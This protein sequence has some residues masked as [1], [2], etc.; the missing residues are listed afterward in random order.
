VS[1]TITEIAASNLRDDRPLSH[2][3]ETTH[4][5]RDWLRDIDGLVTVLAERPERTWGLYASNAYDF[6]VGLFALW[7]SGKI[8]VVAPNDTAG[9]L[10]A[11]GPSVEALL[12][13]LPGALSIAQAPMAN[14]RRCTRTGIDPKAELV[15]FTSGTSGQPKL[16]RKNIAQ[17]DAETATLERM[18]GEELKERV[19]VATVSHQ[20]IYGLLF[21]IL[22]PLSVRRPFCA[23]TARDPSALMKMTARHCRSVCV[24]SPA[25]LKRL[26]SGSLDTLRSGGD[27]VMFS[28]GGLLPTPVAHRLARHLGRPPIEVYGSTETGGIACREQWPDHTDTPWRPL[29][30]VAIAA[31]NDG[32]RVRSP[33]LPDEDWHLTGDQG[34]LTPDGQFRLGPRIDRIAKVEDK[35]VSLV[36]LESELAAITG[37]DEAVCRVR[38]GRRDLICAVIALDQVGFREL[39]S[40][41]RRRYVRRLRDALARRFD[42]VTVPR[43]WRFMESLP[44]NEQGKVSLALLNGLFDPSQPRRF[45]DVTGIECPNDHEVVLTLFVRKDLI[46]FVGHFPEAPVLPGVTQLFWADHFARQLF[47]WDL[48]WNAMEAVKFN[49]V[50]FPGMTV[51][52]RLTT[53]ENPNRLQF[54]YAIDGASCSSGRLI[55]GD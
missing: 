30:G 54:S 51:T 5:W 21:R 43:R 2:A 41:G 10:E 3:D 46:F 22:W 55:Q 50:V 25:Y 28:S 8:P 39:Y 29:P 9:V 6:S 23:D 11:L 16:V 53:R 35:R 48:G 4:T 7:R 34:V 47:G 24:T 15:M 13:D 20:H 44:T 49:R 36:A 17:L 45:P 33:H 12:G 18:W 32:L 42:R 38:A 19:V 40:I 14:T 52:L 1:A 31:S 27:V 37:V 26:S